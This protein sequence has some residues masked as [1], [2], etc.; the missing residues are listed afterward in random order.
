VL[1]PAGPFLSEAWAA[2]RLE[3]FRDLA[4]RNFRLAVSLA[5]PIAVFFAVVARPLVTLLYGA[6][7][8]PAWPA[9]SLLSLAGVFFIG[10]AVFNLAFTAAERVWESV[11]LNALWLALFVA[12]S[13]ATA[14]AWGPAGVGLSLFIS[15]GV[16][17]GICCAY[18]VRVFS[19]SKV[20]APHIAAFILALGSVA[21]W[22]ASRLCGVALWLAGCAITCA[23]GAAFLKAFYSPNEL[24]FAWQTASRTVLR[25]SGWRMED[26]SSAA[27]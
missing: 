18:G 20:G 19:I 13:A 27:L 16:G 21:L 12:L 25:W 3:E 4:R 10:I 22:F 17:Y 7:F 5:V 6:R 1:G 23:A 15:L 9:A 24:T 8:A 11:A 2:G 26:A 14:P